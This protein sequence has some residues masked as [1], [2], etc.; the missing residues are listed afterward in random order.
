MNRIRSDAIVITPTKTQMPLNVIT[1]DYEKKNQRGEG[2]I[3]QLCFITITA[4][5]K[6]L[7]QLG[8]QSR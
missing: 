1:G 4:D 7:V 3:N 8:S 5:Y 2:G 6:T